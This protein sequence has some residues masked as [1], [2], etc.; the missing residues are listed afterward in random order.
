MSF[1]VGLAIFAGALSVSLL[2]YIRATASEERFIRESIVLESAAYTVLAQL[3][4]GDTMASRG[5]VDIGGRTVEVLTTPTS[6][7]ADLASDDA[8][9]LK[10]AGSRV[11]LNVDP[12]VAKAAGGLAALSA[13]LRLDASAEDCLRQVFTYGRGGQARA[14]STPRAFA[15]AP[16]DQVDLRVSIPGQSSTVLWLRAR[17]TDAQT[18]W[19]LH[20]YRRLQNVTPCKVQGSI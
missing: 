19:S 1:T 18:G 3:A 8:A 5:S 15:V 14:T 11:G 6:V 7:R 16:G 2:S 4:V 17:F 13:R 12:E 9:T 10:S 20:D